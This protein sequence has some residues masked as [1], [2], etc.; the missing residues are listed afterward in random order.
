MPSTVPTLLQ[1]IMA[2][3]GCCEE[4]AK[5]IQQ[6]FVLAVLFAGEDP[7]AVLHDFGLEP[8]YVIDLLNLL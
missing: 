8:D 7:E 5:V 2:V 1:A 4:E 6:E 3:D